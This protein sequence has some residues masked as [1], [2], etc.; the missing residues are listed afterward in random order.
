MSFLYIHIK[1]SSYDIPWTLL[2]MHKHV[3]IFEDYDFDPNKPEVTAFLQL[4]QFLLANSFNYL[5]SYLYIPEISELCKK[6]G[7]KYISWVFD[8]PLVSLFH[9]SI[10]NS[11]NYLF[12]FDR[13]EYEFLQTWD[14]PHLYF[15]PMGTNISRTGALHVTDE[16]EQN[17]TCDISFVGNLYN[18]N[19]Y[20]Q[21]IQ[22]LPENIAN[23]MKQYL[24]NHLCNWSEPKPWP[25]LSQEATEY[26]THAF[27]IDQWNHYNM[28]FDLFLGISFL[29]RKLAEM[30]RITVLNTLSEQFSTHLF[31]NS[32]CSS[33]QNYLHEV[34]IHPSV[35]YHTNMN[36]VFYLSRINL[37]I[38][39]PSI[40]TGLP[41]RIYDIMGAGGFVLTN[42][43][44]EIEDYFVV[45]K[46]IEVFHNLDELKEKAAFYLSHEQERLR[47]TL[48]GY[49]KVREHFSYLHQMSK[50]LH[51]VE[52]DE[53]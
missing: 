4:E 37:N 9:P 48:N 33:L 41:Q 10:H 21:F 34:Q 25:R 31:T 36:K 30:D 20:D 23:E 32:D 42:A 11:C 15:L 5:I 24:I 52:E 27:Q 47:V 26:M 40:E 12:I 22:F 2:E 14:I 8:S 46:E 6:Y 17:F 19:P 18:N 35:N 7:Y 51:M 49:Q 13:A 16:D 28:D 53:Q 1:N 45:G 50:M 29:S 39:L 38:T 44:K 43:Q 3:S